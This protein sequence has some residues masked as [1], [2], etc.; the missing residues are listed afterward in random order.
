MHPDH[1]PPLKM[2]VIFLPFGQCSC[3]LLNLSR[4]EEE[5]FYLKSQIKEAISD[6]DRE[7]FR[8][9]NLHY[10]LITQRPLFVPK[11][12][13]IEQQ[14]KVLEINKKTFIG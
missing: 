10:S 2:K 12:K 4:M 11:I 14:L 7:I 9:E 1:A 6:F 5:T 13:E 8:L 3:T